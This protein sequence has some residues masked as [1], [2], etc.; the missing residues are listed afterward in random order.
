MK[1]IGCFAM[2]ELGHSSYLP[3]LETTATYDKK[4]R[5]F[6]INS[7][8]LTSTKWWIGLAGHTA[9]HTV[10]LCQLVLDGKQLGLHWFVVPLRDPVT[11]QA[12]PGINVGELGEKL[13]RPGLDSGWIQFKE[14]RVPHT[15]MLMKRSK[16]DENGVYHPPPSRVASYMPLII[17]RLMIIEQ[18]AADVSKCIAIGIRYSL[19]RSQSEAGF[20]IIEYQFQQYRLLPVLATTYTLTI[21]SRNINNSWRNL[22]LPDNPQEAGLIFQE[23]H[24]LTSIIKTWTG[25]WAMDSMEEIRRSMGGHAYSKYNNVTVISADYAVFTTGGGDNTVL[26]QQGAQYF[27]KELRRTR[28]GKA[29]GS[30]FFSF[31]KEEK[32]LMRHKSFEDNHR[33]FDSSIFR[34]IDIQLT[35]FK[36]LSVKMISHALLKLGN[37]LKSSLEWNNHQKFLI[38]TT[39]PICYLIL[40]EKFV[41][42]IKTSK[43]ENIKPILFKLASLFGLYHLE[44][45][46]AQF[47]Q[48]GYFNGNSADMIKE[49]VVKICSEIRS[50]AVFLVDAFNFPDWYL[51]AP[52]AVH[53]GDIYEKYFS[54]IKGIPNGQVTPYWA[55]DVAPLTAKL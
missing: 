36:W 16:I 23:Y 12:L 49:E 38:E 28:D 53:S 43:E 32:E 33:Q 21:A 29:M 2:T 55:S 48:F 25:W 45:L 15:A 1:V 40:L 31:L 7:P 27:L 54:V 37:S 19:N 30:R 34:E 4:T 17:E 24:I 42:G 6:I 35:A 3:G 14:V 47:L 52:V 8:T 9:T 18:T 20:P 50:S 41:E 39:Q 44:K 10:A 13:G 22:K 51:R 11:G 5:E 46:L 26:A